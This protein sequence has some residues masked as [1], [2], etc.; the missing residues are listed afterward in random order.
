MSDFKYRGLLT[1][2][3]EEADG[4]GS[5]TI[6]NIE[7]HFE[8]GDDFLDAAEAAYQEMEY[9]DLLAIDGVGEASAKSIALTMADKEGWEDGAIFEF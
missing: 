7:Q 5:A 9:D 1:S 2:L 4:V 6:A 3:E 8:E